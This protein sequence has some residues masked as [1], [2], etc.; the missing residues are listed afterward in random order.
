MEAAGFGL[1]T[2]CGSQRGQRYFFWRNPDGNRL[3]V[4]V[5]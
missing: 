4:I 1:R 5:A 3:D 2:P